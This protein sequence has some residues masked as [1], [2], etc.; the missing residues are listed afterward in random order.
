MARERI[1]LRS[2]LQLTTLVAIVFAVI[3]ALGIGT[4]SVDRNLW[5]A[6]CRIGVVN[7]VMSMAAIPTLI[8][9]YCGRPWWGVAA[10]IGWAV[11][12][13]AASPYL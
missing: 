7:Y 4:P 9:L 6:I 10:G 2:L 11:L 13:M 5:E 12:S 3:K 1:N 8:G